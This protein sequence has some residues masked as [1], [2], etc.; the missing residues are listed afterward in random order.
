MELGTISGW[1]DLVVV[2]IIE[3]NKDGIRMKFVILVPNSSQL[4]LIPFNS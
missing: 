1:R 4:Y 3:Q 2:F